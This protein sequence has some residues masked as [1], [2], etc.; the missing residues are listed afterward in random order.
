MCAEADGELAELREQVRV[1]AAGLGVD[2]AL[3]VPAEARRHADAGRTVLA[4]RALRRHTPGQ[5]SLLAAARM[6]RALQ[7]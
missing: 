6:V 5:L 3:A 4:V 2:D 1:L 7:G